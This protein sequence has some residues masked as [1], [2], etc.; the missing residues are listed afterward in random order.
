M[1]FLNDYAARLGYLKKSETTEIRE[2]I[3]SSFKNPS[4]ALVETIDP[5][6]IVDLREVNTTNARDGREQL[7]LSHPEENWVCGT[8]INNLRGSDYLVIN[9]INVAEVNQELTTIKLNQ[10]I[11]WMNDKNVLEKRVAVYS[12]GGGQEW[13]KYFSVPGGSAVL[14]IQKNLVSET[15]SVNKRF[16]VGSQPHRVI[17]KDDF[18]YENIIVL[19]LA[20]DMITEKD[21]NGVCDY[22]DP[23]PVSVYSIIGKNEI[24]VTTKGV[25]QLIDESTNLPLNPVTWS[26]SGDLTKIIF[27]QYSDKA[28]ITALD[29]STGQEYI[30]SAISGLANESKTIK[31]VSLI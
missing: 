21:V 22:K 29:G 18:S 7:L 16:F 5:N 9:I 11:K 27:E 13:D 8:E 24:R 31:I 14:M 25:Y 3:I 19:T 23:D 4:Y 30:L 28:V 15:I 26:L 6:G 10:T 12:K 20:E 1:P 2:N 17:K